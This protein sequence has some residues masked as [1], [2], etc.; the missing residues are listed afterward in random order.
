MR[1]L[2]IALEIRRARFFAASFAVFAAAT[3]GTAS[4]QDAAPVA[5]AM[6]QVARQLYELRPVPLKLDVP[7]FRSIDNGMGDCDDELRDRLIDAL[8]I[9]QA[10]PAN[11][12]VDR[13]IDVRL[14]LSRLDSSD[15][16]ARIQGRYGADP[17]GA[18]WV[19]AQVLGADQT[20]LATLPRTF[21]GGLVCR[22]VTRSLADTIDVALRGRRGSG[23]SIGLTRPDPRVGDLV[24]LTIQ[25]A[26]PD[27]GRVLC[28]NLAAT[29]T[30][31]VLTP[32]RPNTPRLP[33]RSMLVWPRDFA[34]SGGPAGPLCFER[35]Q[36][37]AVLC[38][39]LPADPPAGAERRWRA[40]WPEGR[41]EPEE[42]SSAATVELVGEAL[43]APGVSAALQR[44][45]VRRG[46]SGGL[47]ACGTPLP[48]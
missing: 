27:A 41:D 42:L 20:V 35:E 3:L 26:G 40:A 28:L 34:A 24:A 14:P 4:A 48:R 37:D 25:N 11:A 2:S 5:S 10:D 21:V 43:A 44:Y 1:G 6:G 31:Q 23:L 9:E 38:L 45:Q 22:G 19:E 32:L 36:S 46:P 7:P 29:D 16:A 8:R 12:V 15:A 33:Q 47:S 39:G 18:V 30:A 17:R 13:R